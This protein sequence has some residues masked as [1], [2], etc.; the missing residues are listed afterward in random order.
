MLVLTGKMTPP[1]FYEVFFIVLNE[2][3]T[4]RVVVTMFQR[5]LSKASAKLFFYTKGAKKYISL[6]TLIKTE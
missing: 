6:V 4:L 5:C 2:N 1:T 3:L